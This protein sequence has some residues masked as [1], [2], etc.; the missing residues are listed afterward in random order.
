MTKWIICLISAIALVALPRLASA[1]TKACDALSGAKRQVAVDVLKSKHPHDC[2]DG[3]IWD[4]LHRKP[5]CRLTTRLA[6]QVC[7]LAKAGKNK[8][9]I[10]RVLSRRAT[11][12]TG[13]KYKINLTGEPRAGVGGAKV[14][15]VAYMCARC[16]YCARIT[17]GLYR[18]I[19]SGRLKGKAK[20]YVRLFPI[21][22]HKHSKVSNMALM[23][24]KRLGKFWEY[25]L[26]LYANFDKFDP[27]K[28]PD[29]AQAKGMNREKFKALLKNGG[30]E[31][32]KE[33][34]R[35]NVNATP[36]FY[37]NGRKYVGELSLAALEDALEEEHDRVTG[38]K[39]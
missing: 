27:N 36:T 21:R 24:S 35:N 26:H 4:C 33:G 18:S 1:Q 13:R 29:C 3:T 19:T 8:A 34:V 14:T 25:L 32:K 10:E 17:P 11:S 7:R 6:N 16:P 37:I 12:M 39:H 38:K 2:C 31:S 20:L 23:A 30:V 5:V 28:L 22:S 9:Q 15:L